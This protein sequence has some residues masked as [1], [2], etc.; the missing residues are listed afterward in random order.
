MSSIDSRP[1]PGGRSPGRGALVLE[2]LEAAAFLAQV[3]SQESTNSVV[4]RAGPPGRVRPAVSLPPAVFPAGCTSLLFAARYLGMPLLQDERTSSS[5]SS[6]LP[7]TCWRAGRRRQPDQPDPPPARPRLPALAGPRPGRP[8]AA[9]EFADPA[10]PPARGRRQLPATQG[11]PAP[12]PGDLPPGSGR[13]IDPGTSPSSSAFPSPRP[14]IARSRSGP[15][16][17][18]RVPAPGGS[19]K[20]SPTP[21]DEA[22]CAVGRAPWR[23][24][25]ADR[26]RSPGRNPPEARQVIED[27]PALDELG[28]GHRAQAVGRSG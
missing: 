23:T 10:T 5:S 3:A 26:P 2:L 21:G 24:A 16:S 7:P 28:H 20:L 17:P 12:R 25:A 9:H 22:R 4:L 1:D 8:P 27:F 14:S 11:P 6:T 18:R 15:A 13:A 19:L